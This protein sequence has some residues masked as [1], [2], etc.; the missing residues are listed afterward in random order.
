MFSNIIMNYAKNR[1]FKKRTIRKRKTPY[2][3][4]KTTRKFTRKSSS[5]GFSKRMGTHHWIS[6]SYFGRFKKEPKGMSAYQAMHAIG[7]SA[8][9]GTTTAGKQ[10]VVSAPLMYNQTHLNIVFGTGDAGHS[11]YHNYGVQTTRATNQTNG[12]MFIDVYDCV[13][14]FDSTLAAATQWATDT[15]ELNLGV[16][17]TD[18]QDF[19]LAWKVE[20]T[21]RIV[22]SEGESFEH[23]THHY[24][25][26]KWTIEKDDISSA[27]I[28]KGL[29]R[30]TI[31][32][33]GCAAY[34]E[35]TTKSNV[36]TGVGTIDFVHT[37]SLR[38]KLLPHINDGYIYSSTVPTSFATAETRMDTD[39]DVV[40][41]VTA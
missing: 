37:Y 29:T 34:N 1:K 13:S 36:T 2:N 30:Q 17:L 15:T 19:N 27:T 12:N 25:H 10:A 3:K 16:K 26:R 33:L 31:F 28:Y 6:N 32:I 41:K 14:K 40:A 21:T 35:L 8:S 38:F 39:G 23:I 5:R 20:K 7:D 9:Q 24:P 11:C 22:L 18:S 4:K